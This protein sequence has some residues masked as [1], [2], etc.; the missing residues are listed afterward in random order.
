M[1]R[2]IG[3]YTIPLLWRS[4]VHEAILDPNNTNTGIDNRQEDWFH[5]INIIELNLGIVNIG[6]PIG[7]QEYVLNDS[8]YRKAL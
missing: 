6:I 7:I 4:N 5:L 3:G 2:R 1:N 8:V